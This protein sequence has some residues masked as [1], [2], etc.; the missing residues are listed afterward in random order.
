M[1]TVALLGGE[2][3]VRHP[4]PRWPQSD[5]LE[6]RLLME[7]LESGEWWR[8]TGTQVKA[9]EAAFAAHHGARHA[10]AV[11]N[12][13]HALE[14]AL[15]ALGIGVGDEVLVP[16]LTFVATSMAVFAVGARPIPVDVLPNTWCLDPERTAEAVTQRT[17][18]VI[19]VHFAG[20]VA[21]MHALQA[22]CRSRDLALVED[23]A[24]AHGAV[25]NGAGAGSFGIMAAFSFQNYKLL[26]AGEGGMLL[27]T[28]DEAYE[29]SSLLANC[30][31]PAGDTR[32]EHPVMGSN[33][34][35]SEFQAAVLN[36]QLTRLPEQGERRERSAALLTARLAARGDVFPQERDPRTDRHARYM[37]IFT[38]DPDG[39]SGLDRDTFVAALRAEGVPAVRMY[40]RVQDTG[41][42]APSLL[43]AGGEPDALPEAPVSAGLA[44]RGIWIH[45]RALLGDE[46]TTLQVAE[47]VEKIR[48]DAPR[49]AGAVPA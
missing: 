6:A 17:R 28:D 21:D 47:A 25:W 2:P 16:S 9:F 39:F 43:S 10:M 22:L 13:T 3:V 31:R 15:R 48:A 1:S 45:H 32:Y 20:Q 34:R 24:H 30:G 49:L 40:P 42:F 46:D 44:E 33:Y 38:Y 36:A 26:T 5:G 37:Y 19:P 7:A 29:R 35:M 11:T 41:H 23:A 14:L 27:F 4:F 18:A 8:A 12:G